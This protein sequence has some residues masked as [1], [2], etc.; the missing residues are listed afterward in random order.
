[1]ISALVHEN[2][3]TS[4]T[5]PAE[6]VTPW[7]VNA[8]QRAHELWGNHDAA[9]RAIKHRV[10]K[11]LRAGAPASGK[12]LDAGCGVGAL[13]AYMLDLGFDVTAIDPSASSVNFAKKHV[14]NAEIRRASLEEFAPAHAQRYQAVVANMVMHCTQELDS[15]LSS[16]FE[17]LVPGGLFIAVLPHPTFYLQSRGDIEPVSAAEEFFV[18][19]KFRIHGGQPHDALVPYFHRPTLRY[20]NTMLDVGFSPVLTYEPPQIGPGR[21]HDVL[22]ITA[23]RRSPGCLLPEVI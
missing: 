1:M 21:P 12:V 4:S 10:A 18:E 23:R 3:Y 17:V 7:D 14:A 11:M 9:Y 20:I 2:R 19:L 13:T 5:T 8:A 22:I 15:F 16:A 6:L